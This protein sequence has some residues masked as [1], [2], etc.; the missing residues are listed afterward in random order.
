M[1]I[2]ID[3]SEAEDYVVEKL[4]LEDAIKLLQ[5]KVISDSFWIYDTATGFLYGINPKSYYT[6]ESPPTSWY[7]T[8]VLQDGNM[9]EYDRGVMTMARLRGSKNRF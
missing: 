9:T 8:H 3:F 6:Y 5:D 2:K 4:T 7:A 1:E